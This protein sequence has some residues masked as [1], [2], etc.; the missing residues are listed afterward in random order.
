MHIDLG[1][2]ITGKQERPGRIIEY[3]PPPRAPQIAQN[4]QFI[5]TFWPINEKRVFKLFPLVVHV[6]P[7]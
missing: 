1:E 5:Y 6:S 7:L 4:I 2:R 3:P